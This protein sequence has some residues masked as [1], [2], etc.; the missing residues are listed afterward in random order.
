MQKW[1]TD[2]KLYSCK[3][4]KL[5]NQEMKIMDYEEIYIE[6][7][8]NCDELKDWDSFYRCKKLLN[9]ALDKLNFKL[10]NKLF[11]D[12]GV[13]DGKFIN[14]LYKTKNLNK[15]SVG[16]E[17]STNYVKYA[18]EKNRPV[19]NGNVC[20]LKF[21]DNTFDFVFSHHLLGLT[22]NYKKSLEEMFRV[23]KKDGYM[24]SLNDCPG[25]KRKHFSYID[26]PEIFYD[27][28]KNNNCKV[29]YNNFLDI[30]YKNEWV[31][32]IK[33]ENK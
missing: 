31:I 1:K 17:I 29:I 6:N 10:K 3:R 9:W 24:L 5:K 12:C 19:E 15:K 26:S 2:V 4:Q 21:K 30:G 8:L 33:K 16:I 25:N 20:D 18:Q 32:F 7:F 13:K 22:P 27:F 28:T 11:L 14:W 23:T